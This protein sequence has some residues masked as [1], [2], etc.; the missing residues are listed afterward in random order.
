MTSLREFLFGKYKSNSRERYLKR[1][2]LQLDDLAATTEAAVATPPQYGSPAA[3][4]DIQLNRLGNDTQRDKPAFSTDSSN[5]RHSTGTDRFVQ[6]QGKSSMR[7]QMMAMA[8]EIGQTRRQQQ[9]D[10]SSLTAPR[11]QSAPPESP[12]PPPNP[13]W[14]PTAQDVLASIYNGQLPPLINIHGLWQQKA[15]TQQMQLLAQTNANTPAELP[16]QHNNGNLGVRRT[17]QRT[18]SPR[19]QLSQP[20][21][22]VSH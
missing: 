17:S 3:D 10:N 16:L 13:T 4:H 12:P 2:R 22:K 14:P 20:K 15:A 9:P 21:M 6:H 8:R 18:D 19:I 7:Q 11:E 1:K 5:N